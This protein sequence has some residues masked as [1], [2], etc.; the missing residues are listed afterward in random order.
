[1]LRRPSLPLV[2]TVA[3]LVGGACSRAAEL[4]R[5]VADTAASLRAEALAGTRAFDLVRSLSYEVGPRLAG[6]PGDKAAVAWGLA[7]L[8][9]L[10]F[11]N[12]RAEKVIVP[13]WE[14]GAVVGE[15]LSPHPQPV[16]LA[17]LGGSVGTPEGGITAEVVRFADLDA[18]QAAAPGSLAGKIAFV[19]NR[20]QRA[21]DGSGYGRAVAARGAGPSEAARRGAV[22]YLMRSVGTSDDRI[23]HTGATRYAED[24]PRIPA[25]SLSNPDADMLADRLSGGKPVSF[26]L[27]LGSRYLP[28]AES[29]NVIGEVV[30]R[31]KPEE[32]V[33]LGCH[34]DSWDLGMG[35]VDDAA[36]CAVV[37]E[38]ARLIAGLDERPRRTVRVV[39]F[40]NEE[41]GLSGARAYAERYVADLPRHVVAAESDFGSGKIYS[42]SSR[43]APEAVP[44]VAAIAALLA[45]LG[46]THG[47]NEAGGGADLIPLAPARVPV[48]S[49]DQDGSAYFDIHHTIND[50][51]AKIDPKDL[52]QN[53]AVWAAV[54]YVAAE[55]EGD[56]GRAPELPARR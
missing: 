43:V 41:F 33:L 13:H 29:A 19:D 18:L 14:R 30:G 45:P 15:V 55:M 51:P 37:M 11:A 42:L 48:L 39:L 22:A 1:M 32:I 3:V 54:A 46:V 44:Q 31:E 49:L 26:R 21:R 7:K 8:R 2:F 40:A 6:S 27:V 16:V 28:D 9:E 34:L 5:A 12:V 56:F 23:A 50:T 10:G 25:A 4:P 53:V 24:V 52:D 35:A 17:A 20:M 47:N 38:A 36:G